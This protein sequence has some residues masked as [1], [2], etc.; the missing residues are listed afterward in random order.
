MIKRNH[1]LS[2]TR[3]CGLLDVTRSTFYYKQKA[4]SQEELFIMRRLD[5]LYLQRPSRGSRSMRDCLEQE[6]LLVNRKRVQRLMRKMG[7]TAVYPKKRTSKPGVGHKVYPYLLRHLEINRAGQ[8]YA[9]D[10]TYI[11]MAK[12]FVYLVAVIDWY[13]RKV[14]SWRI[15]N[16]M[17]TSFCVEALQEAIECYGAPEIFNTDQGAQF[18]SEAFTNV[19]RTHRVRISMDGRGRW[20]DNV[21]VERLWRSLKYEEVYVKAYEDMK[22]AKRSIGQ[23]LNEFNSTRRHQSLNRQTP[24]QVFYGSRNRKL[25]A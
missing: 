14:L 7:L 13:S 22:E 8:V 21:Y 19:L 9:A 5:E 17:D 16:T 20:I 3:Q 10:I 11:P 15:S 4:P 25:A 23:Y 12:G 6:G 1:P 18:T 2:I 24:D